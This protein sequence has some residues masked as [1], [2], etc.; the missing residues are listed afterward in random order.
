MNSFTTVAGKLFTRTEA[1]EMAIQVLANQ[2]P[3]GASKD[4]DEALLRRIRGGP[5]EALPQRP[6]QLG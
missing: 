4:A 3:W 6:Q 5:V 1:I 2:H